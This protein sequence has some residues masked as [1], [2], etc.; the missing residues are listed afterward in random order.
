M[1]RLLII[2]VRKIAKEAGD[3]SK[4]DLKWEKDLQV[5]ENNVYQARIVNRH[6]ISY[7]EISKTV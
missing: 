2:C 5:F 7:T 1:I 3:L 4:L 6:L